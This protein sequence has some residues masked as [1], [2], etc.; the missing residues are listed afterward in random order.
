MVKTLMISE[1][2]TSSHRA[3][4]FSAKFAWLFSILNV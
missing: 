4:D 1:G 3:Q 2:Y